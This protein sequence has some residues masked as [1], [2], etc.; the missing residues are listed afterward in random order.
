M[1]TCVKTYKVSVLHDRSQQDELTIL[2]TGEQGTLV[3]L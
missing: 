3:G 2:I 1:Q